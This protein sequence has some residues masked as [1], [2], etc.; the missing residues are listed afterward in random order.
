LRTPKTLEFRAGLEDSRLDGLN[1]ILGTREWHESQIQGFKAVE[2]GVIVELAITYYERRP[3][4]VLDS[5]PAPGVTLALGELPTQAYFL[6]SQP[7]APIEDMSGES[8]VLFNGTALQYSDL[9]LE[10]GNTVLTAIVTGV[11]AASVG[12]KT[13]VINPELLNYDGDPLLEGF[14]LSWQVEQTTNIHQG[15]RQPPA[16]VGRSGVLRVARLISSG[17]A[18]PSEMLD[19]WMKAKGLNRD[20][21]LHQ[22]HIP[23][24]KLASRLFVLYF[25]KLAPRV[26][27]TFP[28][29]GS[30][31]SRTT[32]LDK[33]TVSTDLPLSPAIA[34][35]SDVVF[36]DGSG[37]DS[38]FL[39]LSSDLHTLEIDPTGLTS[40]PGHHTIRIVG[41]KSGDSGLNVIPIISSYTLSD[42][43]G[44]GSGNHSEL[45]NLD[46]DDHLQYSLVGGT[47]DFTGEIGGIDAV[48]LTSF[49]TWGQVLDA[50]AGVTG[51][52]GGDMLKAVYDIANDG[53]VD[54]ANNSD[55]LG[56]FAASE[57]QLT[58]ERG[59]P[60]GY[61][62]LDDNG[63]VFQEVRLFD[64][65][66][67]ASRPGAAVPGQVYVSTDGDAGLGGDP[68]MYVYLNP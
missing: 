46:I 45:T 43:I 65:G 31:I 24:P 51:G 8:P 33:I 56:G 7:F 3:F 23:G 28:N 53:K 59:Q 19:R 55:A 35:E 29:S 66:I 36:I 63:D 48:V 9:S 41:L 52:G 54:T 22:V 18:T 67:Y 61:S 42:N 16:S 4:R 14:D 49:P 39:S 2:K 50:I 57:Y 30:V 21:V 11:D 6:G 5:T 38:S 40:N 37:V 44:G 12:T 25:A 62:T 64:A 47:R 68:V 26:V 13:L 58:G 60:N 27:R 15:L 17:D 32:I 34:G 1:S 10:D 20:H